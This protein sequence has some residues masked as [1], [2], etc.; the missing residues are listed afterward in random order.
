MSKV[1]VESIE[2]VKRTRTAVVSDFSG[3][4]IPQ[5]H[6]SA[7]RT[8]SVV[9]TDGAGNSRTLALD[10][11]PEELDCFRQ[12]IDD[13]IRVTRAKFSARRISDAQS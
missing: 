3:I 5:F 4:E 10:G 9:I 1:Q 7:M 8:I 12:E 6:W 2:Q 13:A 11:T